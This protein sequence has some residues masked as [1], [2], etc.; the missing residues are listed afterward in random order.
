MGMIYRYDMASYRAPLAAAAIAPATM[1]RRRWRWSL[2]EV[3]D[4]R[5]FDV[6]TA[7]NTRPPRYGTIMY[8][9]MHAQLRFS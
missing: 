1:L 4:R 9:L 5:H 8:D 6:L 3:R 7:A 2:P